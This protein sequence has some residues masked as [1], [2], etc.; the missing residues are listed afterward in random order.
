MNDQSPVNES[1]S[2]PLSRREVRRQART[3]NSGLSWVA[4]LLL[5]ALGFVFLLQNMGRFDFPLDNWWAL[6]I[7][8]PTL[9]AFERAWQIYRREDGRLTGEARGS[10]VVG[11]ILTVVTAV[12]FF[13]LSWRLFG[14]LL[15]ILAGIAVLVNYNLPGKE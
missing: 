11:F 7:L 8:I 4:G 13:D 3:A 2:E 6:F 12:L 10:L 15:I 14:P 1:K 5:V 9:G